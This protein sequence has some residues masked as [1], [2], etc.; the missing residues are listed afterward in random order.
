MDEDELKHFILKNQLFV[1]HQKIGKEKTD[2]HREF[3][4]I[5]EFDL[6]KLTL[7]NQMKLASDLAEYIEKFHRKYWLIDYD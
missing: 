5:F 7:P 1:E 2:R 6:S 3:D 4:Y